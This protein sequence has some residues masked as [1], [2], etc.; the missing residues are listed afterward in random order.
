M[1]NCIWIVLVL[2]AAT[3][4]AQ[5][6]QLSTPKVYTW[7]ELRDRMLAANPS[8]KAGELNIDENKAMEITA[9]LR[10]NPDLSFATDQFTPF[11]GGPFR[12]LGLFFPLVESSYLHERQHKRELRLES[13]QKGTAISVSQQNDSIRMLV[14]NLRTAFVQLLQAKAVQRLSK[15]NLEYY[16]RVLKISEERFKA[17]DIAQVDRDRLVLQRVQFES[18]V[19]TAEVNVR[20]A[21]IQLL[22][23]MNDRT[24][25][26][27][28]DVIGTFDFRDQVES[29]EELRRIA[30]EMRPDLKAAM[31][32]VDKAQTDY[33]LAV[34]N[35]STDPTFGVD[36]GHNPPIQV[37]IGFSVSIPLRI[38]DRNQGEKKRT[39]IDIHRNERLR[40]AA[41][42][43][44]F[45]DVDS[46]YATLNSNLVLLR[47]YKVR[48]LDLATKVRETVSFAYERGGASLLDFL[49]AQNDYRSVQLA[50]LNLIGSYMMSANQLNMAVGREA[51]P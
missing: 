13:A 36:V 38:F 3:I 5:P 26:E 42:S 1:R 10:P 21:K 20:T 22:T 8:L 50:Y 15:D 17:G 12:P 39:E 4:C 23:L 19:E 30:G 24:P 6:P 34:A 29:R 43:Q 2:T 31:L 51:I 18:D 48:Y 16:D 32:A 37:Y 35:G 49:M 14:F 45:S 41:E 40:D 27:R 9:N 46:A 7:P 11:T 25:V 44:V 28:F 47:S 33:K